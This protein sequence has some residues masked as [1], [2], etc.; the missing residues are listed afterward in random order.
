MCVEYTRGKEKVRQYAKGARM[1]DIMDKCVP[2]CHTR[3]K[4][5]SAAGVYCTSKKCTIKDKC[6]F[7]EPHV[8]YRGG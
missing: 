7:T 3:T 8:V 5:A 6:A 2:Y 1:L 4:K